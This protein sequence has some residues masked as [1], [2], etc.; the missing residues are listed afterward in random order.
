MILL[1]FL[2]FS[3][4]AQNDLDVQTKTDTMVNRSITLEEAI[5]L[6]ESNKQQQIMLIEF[7]KN[8]HTDDLISVVEFQNYYELTVEHPDAIGFTGGAEC[9]KLNKKTGDSEMI[10]HEHPMELPKLK[11]EKEKINKTGD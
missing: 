4:Q 5:K 6:K 10:W 9:Y 11:Y 2:S 7:R 1:I 3:V 8:Y